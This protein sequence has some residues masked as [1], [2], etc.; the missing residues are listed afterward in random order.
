MRKKNKDRSLSSK[1]VRLT[2]RNCI[3]FGL[4][5]QIVAL[6]FY[7]IA[8][9]SQYIKTSDTTLK[10]LR[11]S[12]V[13]ATD[14]VAY[15]KQVMEIYQGL[16]DEQR[17]KVGTDEYREYFSAVDTTTKGGDY[18]VLVHMI[19]VTF[20]FHTQ[21]DVSSI[22]IA[23]YDEKT[24][25]MVY[26]IDPTESPDRLMPGDWES[27]DHDGMMRFLNTTED[28]DQILYDIGYTENYGLLCTVGVPIWED[29]KIVEYVMADISMDNIKGGMIGFALSM[30]FAIVILTIFIAWMQTSYI[31][32]EITEPINMIADASKRFAS[33]E[34]RSHGQTGYFAEL[35]IHTGDEIEH[36]VKTMSKMEKDLYDYGKNLLEATKE[37]ERIGTEL[38]LATKIQADMLPSI[39]PAFPER[40]D[41]DI[42]ASM[43]P[44]KEVGGDF[45]DFFLIDDDH[46]GIV[47]ADVSGKGVPAALFMM[48][49]KIIIK[50]FAM[51]GNSPAKTLELANTVVCQNNREDMFVTVW[52]GILEISSGR[53]TASNAG[54]EYPIIK[55][56]GG[57]YELLKDKHG[58]TIG[59]LE[60]SKYSEYEIEL[61]KGGTLFLYTDGVPEATNSREELF[62]TDRLVAAMNECSADN[63]KELLASVKKAVDEFVGDAEAFDDLT[64]LGVRLL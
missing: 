33:D 42:F 24:D 7:A 6:S 5:V 48:M 39:F 16:S 51:Q 28:N 34:N 44:A 3:I 18:D 4:V 46:L 52:F 50:N 25:S 31:K 13:N 14:S 35:D 29:G 59:C 11:Q 55:K 22:Y 19:A 58:L 64:M 53:I 45:Y 36:L 17:Q 15:S 10:Q 62:S 1:A 37:K 21:N 47:M 38:T 9:V 41:I 60:G 54:H 26:I 61:E 56:P 2:V 32:Q 49:S 40:E 23:M 30:T 63:A 20:D 27:V 12:I 43:T 57:K 8:L